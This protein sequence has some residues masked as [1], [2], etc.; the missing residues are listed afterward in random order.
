M[1]VKTGEG[2]RTRHSRSCPAP[3]GEC[4]AGTRGG[5][6]PSFEA[7]VRL[8]RRPGEKEGKKDRE[9][10]ATV[11]Y[12]SAAKAAAAAEKWR[13][14]RLDEIEQGRLPTASKRTLREAC[15]DFLNRAE[16][17]LLL[18][19]RGERF[20]PSTLRGYRHDLDTY[21]LPDLGAHN[22]GQ[23]RRRDFQALVD[24]LRVGEDQRTQLSPQK[25]RNVIVPVQVVYRQ[26]R[27]NEEVA[28]SPVEDLDTG[29]AS[30]PRV[31]SIAPEEA[32]ALLAALPDDGLRALYA[33]AYLS[34]ARR[35]ELRAIR[36][37]AVDFNAGTIAIRESWD[38]VAGPVS[39][40]SR[41]GTRTVPMGSEL[42]RVLAAHKLAADGSAD[43]DFVFPGRSPDRPF[44][45]TAVRR[46][47]ATAWK[48]AN[49][50]EAKRA[51]LERRDPVLLL[52]AGLH[53]LRHG[54]VSWMHDAGFSLERIGDYVGHSSEY[55]TNRYRHLLAGHEQEAARLQDQYL[56][57]RA[58]SWAQIRAQSSAEADG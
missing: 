42:R 52:P 9:T 4:T 13:R 49:A 54:Y 41:A 20:K 27:R 36:W 7:A 19:R 14:K 33:A 2:I 23:L 1:S 32:E 46:R 57:R 17:G 47:A 24:R 50:K 34:G 28:T 25:C 18:S 35:G 53:E 40:K 30:A 5:C 22:L 26:A 43:R 16:Q 55:M 51:K 31:R 48:N 44:T 58:G 29:E 15:E 3:D 8:P 38:E 37:D 45:P 56:A 12:G 21:V 11:E 10:F 39:P 6:K